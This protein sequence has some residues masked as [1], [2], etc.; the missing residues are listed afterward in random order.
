MEKITPEN[1]PEKVEQ[2][3][4]LVDSNDVAVDAESGLAIIVIKPDAF[5]KKDRIIKRLEGFGLHVEKTRTKRLPDDFVVGEMY[6]GLPE[7]IEEETLRHFNSGPS[8]IILVKG[9]PDILEK[10]VKVT[11]ENTDPNKCDES[12]IRHLFGEHFMREAS[13]GSK[14]SRN[15]VHRAKNQEEQKDD[16]KKFEPFFN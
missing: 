11:G 8:E 3:E 15:A 1:V 12:S 16:L 7:G 5:S 13:D 10:I 4:K 6:K 2:V 9:G 14:Y